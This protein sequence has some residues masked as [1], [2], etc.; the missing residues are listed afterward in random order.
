MLNDALAEPFVGGTNSGGTNSG[1]TNLGGTALGLANSGG[2]KSGGTMFGSA[3]AAAG[4]DGFARAGGTNSC[5]TN[6][7]GTNDACNEETCEFDGGETVVKR[8]TVYAVRPVGVPSVEPIATI[9]EAADLSHIQPIVDKLPSSP[10]PDQRV[11]AIELI[12]RNADVFSQSEY[13]VGCTDFLTA[14]IITDDHRP[15]TAPL[16]R[17]ARAHLDVID[18][19]LLNLHVVPGLLTW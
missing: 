17:H 1:G 4:L 2:T 18:E 3:G 9:S 19:T 12:K 8:A 15:I 7:C 10:T 14:R 6:L 11:Q 13:D 5:G 16:R